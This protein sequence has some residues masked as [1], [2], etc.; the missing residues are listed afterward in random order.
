MMER[1]EVLLN[2]CLG[3]S[4]PN[5]GA[6]PSSCPVQQVRRCDAERC[7]KP[8]DVVDRDVALASFDAAD[9]VAMKPG[10]LR[11]RLLRQFHAV[12][13]SANVRGEN[14]SGFRIG[15]RFRALGHAPRLR[16]RSPP[17]YTL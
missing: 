11:K 14:L 12:A 4:D 9:I 10:A 17:V 5:F 15:I 6:R 16:T 7:R 13:E 3:A 1:E 8:T 2:K